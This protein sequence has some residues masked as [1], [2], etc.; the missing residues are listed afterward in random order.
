MT[1]KRVQ[2]G[3][4]SN[5]F[6]FPTLH[7]EEG[8]AGK[9]MRMENVKETEKEP[10]V[11]SELLDEIAGF[12]GNKKNDLIQLDYG[13]HPHHINLVREMMEKKAKGK[14]HALNQG[15]IEML[16][17]VHSQLKLTKSK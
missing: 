5:N 10:I 17:R 8:E 12:I 1:A 15:N 7:N 13:V 16:Q 6:G 9:R 4:E 14:L 11:K 2:F 3:G